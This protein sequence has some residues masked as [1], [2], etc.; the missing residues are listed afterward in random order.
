MLLVPASCLIHFKCSGCRQ[1]TLVFW[2]RG[3]PKLRDTRDTVT[4]H[5]ALWHCC[6]VQT[7]SIPLTEKL[8]ISLEPFHLNSMLLKTSNSQKNRYV[9]LHWLVY[10][11]KK[12]KTATTTTKEYVMINE[13]FIVCVTMKES[14]LSIVYWSR[15]FDSYTARPRQHLSMNHKG[16]NAIKSFDISKY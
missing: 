6:P 2:V 10:T 9:K 1:K 7:G 11:I 8:I 15:P 3:Y 16:K 13:R 4:P 14:S 5:T 12:N